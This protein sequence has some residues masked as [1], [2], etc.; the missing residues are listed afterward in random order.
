MLK[1]RIIANITKK[2]LNI[3]RVIPDTRLREECLMAPKRSLTQLMNEAGLTIGGLAD[4]SGLSKPTVKRAVRGDDQARLNTT[5]ATAIAEVFDSPVGEINWPGGLANRGRP[6]RSGGT[7][8][9]R[10]D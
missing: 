10:T 3:N 5:S 4:K 8:T 1:S 2:C 9:R 6:A 7:Y